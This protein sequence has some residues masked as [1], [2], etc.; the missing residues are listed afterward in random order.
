MSQQIGQVEIGEPRTSR[1]AIS[2]LVLGISSFLCWVFTGIPAIILG[3]IAL[4]DINKSRGQV[5]GHGMALTG[6]ITGCISTFLIVP[7]LILIALLLPAIQAAR[8]AARRNQSNSQ[9]QQ[10]AL[11]MLNYETA[12]QSLPAP[13][14]PGGNSQLSWRVHI[15]PYLSDPA[16]AVLYAQFHLDEP[17]D[18]PHNRTLIGLMPAVFQNPTGKNIPPGHTTYLLPTGPG[19]AFPDASAAPKSSGFADGASNT[20]VLLE[21]DASQAVEWTKP[22][23]WRLNASDAMAGLGNLRAFGFLAA[24]ADG[25][26]NFISDE[27]QP[28]QFRAMLSPAGEDRMIGQ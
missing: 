16:A 22:Q 7:A 28:F 15:L 24:T 17:W 21:A 13:G 27:T 10:I 6:I 18:S 11:A 25:A 9:M 2:S 5:T 23:D 14:G 3:A 19:T 26:V 4:G 12:K 20:I 1:M 8:E